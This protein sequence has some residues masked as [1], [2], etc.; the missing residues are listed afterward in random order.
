[1]DFFTRIASRE[2]GIAPVVQPVMGS[3]YAP[4]TD[5]ATSPSDLTAVAAR[6]NPTA[7]ATAN[8]TAGPA[9]DQRA[10]WGTDAA[11]SPQSSLSLNDVDTIARPID[12]VTQ[13]VDTDL[14]FQTPEA[15]VAGTDTEERSVADAGE[16]TLTRANATPPLR[17]ASPES[18]EFIVGQGNKVQ[19]N[20]EQGPSGNDVGAITE[21]ESLSDERSRRIAEHESEIAERETVIAEHERGAFNSTTV[22]PEGSLDLAS[23]GDPQRVDRQR[24][25]DLRITGEPVRAPSST[26]EFE[27]ERE[28]TETAELSPA[29]LEAATQEESA[30]QQRPEDVVFAQVVARQ[31]GGPHE[32]RP[33][34]QTANVKTRSS[35]GREAVVSRPVARRGEGASQPPN[36]LQPRNA[37]EPTSASERTVEGSA[38]LPQSLL[39]R[40]VVNVPAAAAEEVGPQ[41]LTDARSVSSSIVVDAH[42]VANH[43]EETLDR[44]PNVSGSQLLRDVVSRTPRRDREEAS[45]TTA[46]GPPA[47]DVKSGSSLRQAT[48]DSPAIGRQSEERPQTAV[49]RH[50]DERPQ[51]ATKST[52]ASQPA[53]QPRQDVLSSRSTAADVRAIAPPEQRRLAATDSSSTTN[54]DQRRA[55]ST[56]S[57][58]AEVTDQPREKKQTPDASSL[59]NRTRS[60]RERSALSQ[61]MLLAADRPLRSSRNAPEPRAATEKTIRVTIGRIEV[62]AA[63]PPPP[64][65]EPPTPSMPKL[66]L[67]EFLRQQNGRRK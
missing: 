19:A 37:S 4:T 48:I 50:K 14:N 46:A 34:K 39:P 3:R 6:T 29:R 57:I 5:L 59:N 40:S 63:Q 13:P 26:A 47:L 32:E 61:S 66:S 12:A 15:I 55:R 42:V 53:S 65:V 16:R 67:D 30:S 45:S 24:R 9:L 22:S 10:A 38:S 62:H 17:D 43:R 20:F 18:S 41:P 35:G 44:T 2:L 49:A 64:P 7:G 60:T 1:M 11:E 8:P 54:N 28:D 58:T 21:D 51:L 52:P 23:R 31:E 56:P 27:S 33:P 25:A 36:A